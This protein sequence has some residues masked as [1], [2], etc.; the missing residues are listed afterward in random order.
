MNNK[1]LRNARQVRKNVF[2]TRYEDIAVE[3]MNYADQ[4]VGKT[5]YCNCDTPLESNFVRYLAENFKYLELK[6]LITTHYLDRKASDINPQKLV[7]TKAD[8]EAGFF[9]ELSTLE[10]DRDFR[11]EECPDLLRQ[12]YVV[13]TNPP[14]SL[15]REYAGVIISQGKPFVLMGTIQAAN[16]TPM[17]QGILL[18]TIKSGY[19]NYGKSLK[20]YVPAGYDS[21]KFIDGRKVV[22]VLVCLWT[23]LLVT[24]RQPL[25]LKRN[26]TPEAYPK[27]KSKT[28]KGTPSSFAPI[29]AIN[30]DCFADIPCDYDGLMGVPVT[31]LGKIDYS[32]F[33]VVSK[34]NNGFIGNRKVFTR[35]IIRRK[36]ASSTPVEKDETVTIKAT[37]ERNQFTRGLPGRIAGMVHTQV[38]SI[39]LRAKALYT[40]ASRVCRDVFYL[41][42]NGKHSI[43]LPVLSMAGHGHLYWYE[44]EYRH[45]PKVTIR[46]PVVI[47]T[48]LLVQRWG[49]AY[50]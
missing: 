7:L 22:E 4:S 13:V 18:G 29:D 3:L 1:S 6:S 33:E 9:S 31:I 8:N 27:Y 40:D 19:T 37:T 12:A 39:G 10:G 21:K 5:A 15:L 17:L 48:P 34:I 32:Q 35:I 47:R 25:Q 42:C 50:G 38:R 44:Y 14:F 24:N 28:I 43:L 26:Y 36:K 41:Y 49:C 45:R 11:S 23:N 16:Y 30:V 46:W 20:F 2:Y